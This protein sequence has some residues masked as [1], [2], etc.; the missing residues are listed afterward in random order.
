MAS[1]AIIEPNV[2]TGASPDLPG[3]F[4]RLETDLLTVTPWAA[5]TGERFTATLTARRPRHFM[6]ASP[7]R[8]FGHVPE[9]DT[10]SDR[11]CAGHHGVVFSY[12]VQGQPRPDTGIDSRRFVCR[13]PPVNSRVARGSRP[14]AH[15]DSPAAIP[16]RPDRL[17][18]GLAS[19]HRRRWK[20]PACPRA[21]EPRRPV[22][23]I[24][25]AI[26]HRSARPADLMGS[27]GPSWPSCAW[28][29]QGQ[30]VGPH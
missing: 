28:M 8:R 14:S 13:S 1:F 11:H 23:W 16:V 10:C 2:P 7:V 30:S 6:Q 19:R 17:R 29:T 5:R 15:G 4:I 21:A 26:A 18:E 12:P 22:R 25:A 20:S 9:A 24:P 3:I 27:A